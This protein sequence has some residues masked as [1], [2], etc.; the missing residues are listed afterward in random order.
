MRDRP[1]YDTDAAAERLTEAPP[2]QSEPDADPIGPDRSG[3]RPAASRMRRAWAA[4]AWTVGG[5]GLFVL[6]LRIARSKGVNS[7]A[8][9]NALQAWDLL[10]GHLLLHGWII[11]DATYY[12]F[13]LP[14][15]ALIEI[16]FGTHTVTMNVTE[17]LVYLIVAAWSVAIAVTGSRGPARVA[18]AAVV[19]AVLAAPALI[20]SD[21]WIP[22]G[23]PDHTGTTVFLL[24]PCLLVDRLPNRW[25]TAPLICV[26]LCAGQIGDVTVRY[27]A[28]PA[29]VAVCAYQVLASRKLRSHDA[30]NLLG[31]AAS[32]PLSLWVRSLMLHFGGYLMVSPK[33]RLAPESLWGHNAALAWGAI[34]MLYGAQP[35]PGAASAGTIVIFGY[36]CLLIAVIGILRVLCR[37]RGARPGERVLV[38]AIAANMTV[39]IL[40][41]LPAVNSPHDIVAVLPSGAVLGA[42]ALVPDRIATRVMSLAAAG[43]A[44]VAALLP[45]SVTA[46]Q[47]FHATPVAPLAA[48]LQAHGLTYGLGDYW[49]SSSVTLAT[50]SQVQVRTVEVVTVPGASAP[51]VSFYAW[52]TNT[53][54]FDPARHYANFVI[55]D[56]NS[57]DHVGTPVAHLFGK[58]DTTYIVDGEW[59]VLVYSKNL[60]TDVLPAPLPPTS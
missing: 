49:D 32:F 12:T 9:N 28:V 36:A 24:I 56:L 45:L 41:T 43:F 6:F 17:A 46:E 40:S 8:A 33:T 50:G 21:M 52:E 4:L 23:I 20:G 5:A 10:H 2:A 18:R 30:A 25:F 27:V 1:P 34:R 15:I 16:F 39:Y 35:G 7:D 26:I 38:V 54:W 11:G 3:D 19:V 37:W 55:V 14:L 60:L 58:P 59:Q 13:E 42:R 57:P 48:W 47:S 31:A 29:I 22:L 51:Q 53:L 44:M